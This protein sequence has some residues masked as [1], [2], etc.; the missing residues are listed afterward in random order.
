LTNTG[1]SE[2]RP[3]ESDSSGNYQ[4]VN[5][6]PG[7]YKIDIEKA[8]FKHVTRDEIVVE[9]QA[10]VRIDVSMQV[11]DVGQTVEVTAQTPLLQTESASLGQ[12]VEARK[13]QEMPLNGR[14]VL[15]LVALVPGVVPQGNAMANPTGQNIFAFGNYQIGGGIAG[16]NAAYID[17]APL[18]VAQGS[19]IALVPTQDAMQEFRVQTNAL[20]PEFGR[21][22]GGVINLTS[23]SGT[24][25]FHGSAYEF[26]RNRVLNANTFFNNAM[27]R[28]GP[29]SRKTSS[30]S[31]S[32]GR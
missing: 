27:A 21:F 29:R 1:T 31:I 3:A 11:G 15:N 7:R 25:Q 16:Q 6:V 23:K 19:L 20:G 28:Y 32:A 9:V 13:V 2:R 22:T 18:N 24:N 17:G 30:A 10:T 8:G 14:N 12:V 4:F 5:L 26:L